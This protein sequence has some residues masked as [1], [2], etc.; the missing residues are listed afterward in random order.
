MNQMSP[1]GA[2]GRSRTY[3]WEDPRVDPELLRGMTGLELMRAIIAG[4]LPRPPISLTLGF[5]LNEAFEGRAVFEGQTGEYLYNP[6]GTV[7]GGFAATLL[8]SCM[9][10]A[11]H[12]TLPAGMAYTTVELKINM[13]RPILSTTGPVLAEGKVIH[14]GGRIATAEGRLVA[15]ADGKL[16]AHGSTTCLV[17]PI[18]T[19]GERGAR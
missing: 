3:S 2:D 13:V 4:R 11:V 5:T 16:Y 12:T 8:D 9:G 6:I 14:A 15:K 18:P 1:I 17:F 19:A 7:H 10:C